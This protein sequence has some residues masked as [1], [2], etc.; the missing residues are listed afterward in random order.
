[1][2]K[3]TVTIMVVIRQAKK[4]SKRYVYEISKESNCK[5]SKKLESGV[6]EKLNILSVE[7]TVQQRQLRQLGHVHG[8]GGDRKVK[9]VFEAKEIKYMRRAT[10]TVFDRGSKDSCRSKGKK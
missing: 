4:Q 1:M 3:P 5:N 9:R 2:T 7:E 10:A 8:M 6:Q